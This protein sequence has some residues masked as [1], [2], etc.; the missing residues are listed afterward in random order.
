M[1]QIRSTYTRR[2][3]QSRTTAVP[4]AEPAPTH[5][6]HPPLPAALYGLRPSAL[7]AQLRQEHISFWLVCG[8]LIFE[9]VRPQTIY[10]SIDILPW[11]SLLVIGALVTSFFDKNATRTGS[12]LSVFMVLYGVVVLLSAT[13]G[14]NPSYSFSRLDLYF[15]WLIIYFAI[16]RTVCTKTRFFLF[17]TLY[18]L[19]NFKMS[20]H[21]FISWAS[22]GFSF[23]NWGVTGSPG[24][25]QNSGEF[26]IQLCVFT[27]MVVA[28][29]MAVRSYF[30]PLMRL[31][32]YFVPVTAIGCVMASTSRGAMVGLAAA[33]LWSFK[34]S[35]HFFRTVAIIASIGAAIYVATPDEFLERFQSSGSDR[36]S[37][38]R[39]DRWQKGWE[40]MKSHPLLG[41]GHQNWIEYY[42]ANLDDGVR[43]TILVH[44]IFVESGTEHGFLGLGTLVLLLIG[45]FVVNSKTRAIARTQNDTFSVYAAHGMDAAT[46]GMIVSASFVTVLYYPYV[47]IHAAFV[48]SLSISVR[49]AAK[50]TRSASKPVPRPQ[51]AARST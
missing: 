45:M 23:A 46:I 47:W 25:F 2:L 9:Y 38:I 30:S 40:T 18:M 21:G 24:W 26:G 14:Y 41:V 10:R 8:Y 3:G 48:A 11:A 16:I 5:E 42:Q 37:Q 35:K 22:R 33:A 27:P 31:L 36:T 1:N 7:F 28:F 49:A 34:A 29:V 39:M 20:Q 6:S 15:N 43:G 13:F 4:A 44:N 50:S 12:A 51:P 19:C 32:L 17:F